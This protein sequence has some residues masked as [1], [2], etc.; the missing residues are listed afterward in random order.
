MRGNDELVD[1]QFSR[2]S[3]FDFDP[4]L[5]DHIAV[6]TRGA[7]EGTN[8]EEKALEASDLLAIAGRPA[9]QARIPGADTGAT[10]AVHLA[11]SDQV[12]KAQFWADEGRVF[13]SHGQDHASIELDATSAEVITTMLGS[14]SL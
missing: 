13:A 14:G 7:P 1:H 5:I 4:Q 8:T 10:I 6:H 2:G 12:H 3:V 9:A 11:G